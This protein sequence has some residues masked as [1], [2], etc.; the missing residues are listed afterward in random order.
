MSTLEYLFLFT[1]VASVAACVFANVYGRW[2]YKGALLNKGCTE[3]PPMDDAIKSAEEIGSFLSKRAWACGCSWCKNKKITGYDD[4]YASDLFW[5]KNN[6]VARFIRMCHALGCEVIVRERREDCGDIEE[7]VT[8]EAREV[9]T[10]M[11][12]EWYAA[13]EKSHRVTHYINT[14]YVENFY[15]PGGILDT[16]KKAGK[17]EEDKED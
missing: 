3:V 1:V 13:W 14:S 16:L 11:R 8:D 4:A 2:R 15:E 6:E 7:S 12:K 17:L 9:R 10:K 5:G